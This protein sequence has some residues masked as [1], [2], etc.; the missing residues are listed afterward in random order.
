MSCNSGFCQ[1]ILVMC[2]LSGQFSRGPSDQDLSGPAEVSVT[3][4][5][6]PKWSS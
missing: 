6:G 2:D 3:T 4:S 1:V 5:M